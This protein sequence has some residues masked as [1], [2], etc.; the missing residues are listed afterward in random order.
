MYR[1][2]QLSLRSLEDVCGFKFLWQST[3]IGGIIF[4]GGL[5]SCI[6]YIWCY[7]RGFNRF[8]LVC[9]NDLGSEGCT[10]CEIYLVYCY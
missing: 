10:R 7:G 3:A 6:I 1:V 2:N 5:V 9:M 8:D 4:L